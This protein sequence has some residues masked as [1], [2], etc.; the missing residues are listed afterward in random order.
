MILGPIF[1]AAQGFI[2]G[3][4]VYGKS[5]AKGPQSTK[6]DGS[7]S[8]RR[9]RALSI[10]DKVVPSKMGDDKFSKIAPGY[11]R[12]KE[13]DG[14]I[15]SYSY[16][17]KLPKGFTGCG[18]LPCYVGRKLGDPKGITSCGLEAARKN[19]KA[20]GAWVDAGGDARPKPGDILLN[21]NDV[22]IPTHIGIFIGINP[23]GT[24]K[25]A[26]TGQASGDTE[27]AKYLTRVYDPVH[28]TTNGRRLAGWVDLDKV[29]FH[30]VDSVS[31]QI[32]DV[33]TREEFEGGHIDGAINIHVDDI[34][35]PES[36]LP[37]DR[38][39]PVFVYCRSGGRSRRA[40]HNLASKGFD[41][42]DLGGWKPW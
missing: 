6:I 17:E 2:A 7:L 39:R 12:V 5:W 27:E 35:C 14:S 31:G 19:A 23:D 13:S 25:T 24:W 21:A 9:L 41:V 37:I 4:L 20:Q 28:V 38:S 16:S 22:D 18:Y 42:T 36:D 33:R 26:D 11:R 3:A 32:I 1:A 40:A 34:V 10:I 8:A 29:Q 30:D 15:T